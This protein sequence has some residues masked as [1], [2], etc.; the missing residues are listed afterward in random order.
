MC[1]ACCASSSCATSYLG[2]GDTL[3]EITEASLLFNVTHSASLLKNT[4]VS[5][6]LSFSVLVDLVDFEHIK[7]KEE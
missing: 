4:T 3:E 1:N 7:K 6:S 2:I 5:L